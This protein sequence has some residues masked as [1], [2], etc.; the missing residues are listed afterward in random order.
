VV[1]E[2]RGDEHGGLGRTR[3]GDVESQEPG[4]LPGDEQRPPIRREGFEELLLRHEVSRR[5][6]VVEEEQHQSAVVPDCEPPTGGVRG[7]VRH[8]A[9]EPDR[10][11]SPGEVDQVEAV[12]VTVALDHADVS[13]KYTQAADGAAP[14][15]HALRPRR[16]AV[17]SSR[18]DPQGG[19]IQRAHLE[20][21]ATVRGRAWNEADIAQRGHHGRRETDAP[22]L[23]PH[24]P[25][26]EG[27]LPCDGAGGQARPVR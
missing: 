15:D 4:V 1:P 6:P 18:H 23:A 14:E 3:P 24:L 13:G 16:R 26:E 17:D 21:P 12:R 25:H 7:D 8:A 10:L 11:P 22:G 5:W 27:G 9:E 2:V 20:K 19:G